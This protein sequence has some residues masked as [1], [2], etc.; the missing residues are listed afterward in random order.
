MQGFSELLLGI[1]AD[2]V[3]GLARA[4]AT[5]G[6]F[7]SR[8]DAPDRLSR[9]GQQGLGVGLGCPQ[10]GRKGVR[11][12]KSRLAGA[13]TAAAERGSHRTG[14]SAQVGHERPQRLRSA[15]RAGEPPILGCPHDSRQA[16][17]KRSSSPSGIRSRAL[18]A[19]SDLKSLVRTGTPRSATSR[20]GWRNAGHRTRAFA[21]GC[22]ECLT[23]TSEPQNSWKRGQSNR[24]GTHS[25]EPCKWRRT[26]ELALS[27]TKRRQHPPRAP[28]IVGLR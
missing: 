2:G 7:G 19:R 13:L 10:P 12:G 9:A 3:R 24:S 16:S 8:F 15:H 1:L 6:M 5:A 21:C 26:P 14:R 23:E 20:R 11:E 27:S 25:Q 4:G 18:S 17:M 28:K 22:P